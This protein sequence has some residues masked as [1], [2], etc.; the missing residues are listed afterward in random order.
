MAVFPLQ[1]FTESNAQVGF[2]E[3][4]RSSPLGV[5]Y[6]GQPKGVYVGFTPSV[7]GSTLT[8]TPSLALGY[9]VVKV[10][11]NASP[12]LMDI[13]TTD[14][15]VLDFTGQPAVDFPMNVIARSSY[16]ADGA[17]ITS[18]EIFTRSDTVTIEFDEVLLCV[19]GGPAASLTVV[20]DP[21]L[22]ER[23]EPLALANVDFGFMRGGA[24]EELRTAADIVNEV[25]AARIGLDGTIHPDL[26]TRVAVDYG[27]PAMAGRLALFSRVLRSNDY[28]VVAGEGSVVVSGSFSEIERDFDPKITLSGLGSETA[29]GALAGPNDLNRNV[30]LVTD[31]DTGYRT[32][33]DPTDRRI[34]FGRLTGPNEDTISGE[35]RFLNASKDV[36]ATDGNGQ[37]TVELQLGNTLI[38][39]D[40][41]PYE[42]EATTD[43][44]NIVLRTAYASATETN[45]VTTKQR[46]TV[47][48]KKMVGTVETDASLPNN[49]TIRFFFPT[50]VSME[51]SNFDWKLALHTAAERV[52]LPAAT[53]TTP[54]ITRLADS[55]ALLGAVNIQNNGTPLGGGPFHTINFNAANANVVITANSGEVQVIEIGPTGNKGNDG[56]TGDPGPI[57][58][59]G[60]GFAFV[61][62]FEVSPEFAGILFSAPVPFS[63]TKDM[64][65]NIHYLHGGIRRWRDQGFFAVGV[66]SILI[67]SILT[68]SAT[69]GRIEGQIQGDTFVMVFLSSAGD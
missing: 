39:P 53:T 43:D 4:Y 55:N 26:S 22:G 11:S 31:A 3:D 30:V 52:P 47:D 25:I 69:E 9:S 27:A 21:D 5:K 2:D 18:G 54:G 14:A 24:I 41:K 49:T 51:R 28:S 16:F 35:W 62:S 1:V 65:H 60:P 57:G 37:A 10:T 40:G 15:I 42:V 7:F 67:E 64:T 8:L 29:E 61:N 33:D 50:F 68:I 36:L 32:I 45:T 17:S 56:P 23:D 46:W 34:V 13:I 6:A 48:L 63:F 20:F 12:G 66:D 59:E 38:G 58:A 19:V 44:N